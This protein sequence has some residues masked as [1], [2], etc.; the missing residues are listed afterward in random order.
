MR[1]QQIIKTQ[2]PTLELQSRAAP[3]VE[4]FHS[5]NGPDTG[6]NSRGR[7]VIKKSLKGV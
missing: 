4:A 6:R 1:T 2:E 5:V 7:R 3:S